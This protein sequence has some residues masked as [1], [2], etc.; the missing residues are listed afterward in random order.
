MKGDSTG[1]A[2]V[3]SSHTKFT[4]A[5]YLL[6]DLVVVG[7]RPVIDHQATVRI[8]APTLGPRCDYKR[9]SGWLILPT[10]GPIL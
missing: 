2:D 10:K 4:A 7:V 1:T 5:P 8:R 6:H 9:F 3:N